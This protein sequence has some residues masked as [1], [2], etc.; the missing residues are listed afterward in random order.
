[1][2]RANIEHVGPLLSNPVP[3]NVL[4]RYGVHAELG[5]HGGENG[6][7]AEPGPPRWFRPGPEPIEAHLVVRSAVEVAIRR[8]R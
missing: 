2:Q 8:F 7:F 1:V 6:S 3:T 5:S 4:V